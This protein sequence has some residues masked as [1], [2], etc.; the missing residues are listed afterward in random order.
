LIDLELGFPGGN[1]LMAAGR[2]ARPLLAPLALRTT[3]LP[4]TARVAS[5][6]GLVAAGTAAALR[7]TE[8]HRAT[9]SPGRAQ[10]RD[11]VVD[12]GE[13]RKGVHSRPFGV[14]RRPLGISIEP[15][16]ASRYEVRG[17]VPR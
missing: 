1:L 4:R 13:W 7:T 14:G 3:P 2:L 6:V 12:V 15:T 9:G 17:S 11:E 16:P 5:V 8:K 10:K